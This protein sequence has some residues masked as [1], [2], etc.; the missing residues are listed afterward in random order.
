MDPFNEIINNAEHQNSIFDSNSKFSMADFNNNNIERLDCNQGLDQQTVERLCNQETSIDNSIDLSIDNS[1]DLSNNIDF[2]EVNKNDLNSKENILNKF[3]LIN[4]RASTKTNELSMGNN[5]D[6]NTIQGISSDIFQQYQHNHQDISNH[7]NHSTFTSM[8]HCLINQQPLSFLSSSFTSNSCHQNQKSTKFGSNASSLSSNILLSSSS[9]SFSSFSSNYSNE[10]H[11]SKQQNLQKYQDLRRTETNS[12]NFNISRSQNDYSKIVQIPP[13]PSALA[14]HRASLPIAFH[15]TRTLTDIASMDQLPVNQFSNNQFNQLDTQDFQ[16]NPINT[17]N[18]NSNNEFNLRYDSNNNNVNQDLR[19]KSTISQ[20]AELETEACLSGYLDQTPAFDII[21]QTDLN[22]EDFNLSNPTDLATCNDHITMPNPQRQQQQEVLCNPQPQHAVLDTKSSN[23][24]FNSYNQFYNNMISSFPHHQHHPQQDHYNPLISNNIHE[25]SHNLN[26]S[27]ISMMIPTATGIFSRSNS[28]PD[29]TMNLDKPIP[30]SN[31]Y[32]INN[33]YC[34]YF[35]SNNN[36]NNVNS[37]NNHAFNSNF[38]NCFNSTTNNIMQPFD[39]NFST[40]ENTSNINANN[41]QLKRAIRRHPS[42][43]KTSMSECNEQDEDFLADFNIIDYLNNTNSNNNTEISNTG[44]ANQHSNQ[45]GQI[46]F[47]GNNL[48]ELNFGNLNQVGQGLN[49]STSYNVNTSHSPTVV[50]STNLTDDGLFL[51]TDALTDFLSNCGTFSDLFDDL[52]E[53]EDLMSLVTFESTSASNTASS[54]NASNANVNQN[55]KQTQCDINLPNLKPSNN[56]KDDYPLSNYYDYCNTESSNLNQNYEAN[57]DD[58]TDER[59][60]RSA[61]PSPTPQKKKSRPT[62]NLPWNKPWNKMDENDRLKAVD[63]L[64]RIINDEMGLREQLEIIRILNPDAKLKPTDKQFGIDL[65]IIDDD[66]F[67]R[68]KDIIKAYGF[69]SNE[70]QLN[71]NS[72]DCS[73]NSCPQSYHLA[74]R[75]LR[76]KRAQQRLKLKIKKEHRQIIKESKSGLFAKTEVIPLSKVLPE[77][78]IEVDILS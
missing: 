71:D 18:L 26:N 44:E 9:S 41:G 49:K 73:A 75:E 8:P 19:S 31:T 67:K 29:L 55:I 68:I 63:C 78:D 11:F 58:E 28:Q 36:S 51:G 76:I 16:L 10:S 32:N 53:I 14:M 72:S 33:N 7:E 20:S 22:L 17:N 1:I 3:K 56:I 2:N 23:K 38:T 37:N 45:N 6:G 69:F 27:Q 46:S 40:N 39:N 54:Q 47:V 74:K 43:Y 57:L 50:T 77:E 5:I 62:T 64:T 59:T 24:S 35:N 25:G 15:S 61:P 48:N 65:K 4:E 34:Y 13:P 12:N 66:K 21:K 60:T 70:K 42:M 52:P 30:I